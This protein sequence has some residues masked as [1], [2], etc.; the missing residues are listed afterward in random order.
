M[1]GVLNRKESFLQKMKPYADK[2]G[3]D[4]GI[5]SNFILAHWA[6]ETGY[7]VNGGSKINN[8]AGLMAYPESPYGSNGKSFSSIDDFVLYYEDFLKKPRY[9]GIFEASNVTDFARALKAGKYATDPNYAYQPAWVEA[10]NMSSGIS[11]SN[12]AGNSNSISS[13]SPSS[14][15]VIP[16][17]ETYY[18]EEGTVWDLINP[19]SKTET[20]IGVEERLAEQ[21]NGV[22]LSIGVFI[23]VLFLMYGVFY[24][25]SDNPLVAIMKRGVNNVKDK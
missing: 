14:T 19:L 16:D 23:M 25:N 1:A 15:Y 5:D 21:A 20:R 24:K 17:S 12:T 13:V 2:A 11:K 9:S 7:G 3:S 22:L 8:F 18:T 4:L 6:H 10:Y